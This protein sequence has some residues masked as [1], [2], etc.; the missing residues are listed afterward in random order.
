MGDKK[1]EVVSMLEAAGKELGLAVIWKHK[2]I[3]E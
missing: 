3:S 2:G 1:E